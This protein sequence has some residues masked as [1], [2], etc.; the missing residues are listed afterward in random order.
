VSNK[1][2]NW[3]DEMAAVLDGYDDDKELP[4][5]LEDFARSISGDWG[6]SM[7]QAREYIEAARRIGF[8]HGN[9]SIPSNVREKLQ[10]VGGQV[11]EST[12]LAVTTIERLTDACEVALAWAESPY[13]VPRA[14]RDRLRDKLRE[15]LG[16]P[17]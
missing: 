13:G 12:D 1:T 14:E 4:F 2:P 10:K 11:K 16:K 17:K 9:D 5:P 6:G 7:Q 8:A 3:N 15:A